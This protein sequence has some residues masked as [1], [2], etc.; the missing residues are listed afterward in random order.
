[1]H[2]DGERQGQGDGPAELGQARIDS[3]LGEA[4]QTPVD[5]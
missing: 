1:M 5:G 2:T 4:E 3:P